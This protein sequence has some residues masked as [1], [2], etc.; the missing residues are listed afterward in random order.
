MPFRMS[1][2]FTINPQTR[3]LVLQQ[4]LPNNRKFMNYWRKFPF[5]FAPD[6]TR[7]MTVPLLADGDD[8]PQRLL[9]IPIQAGQDPTLLTA[10]SKQLRLLIQPAPD[11]INR[12]G[13]TAQWSRFWKANIPHK[14][15]T[16]WWRA[17]QGKI[18]TGALRSRIWR[19]QQSPECPICQHPV[20]DQ[21]HFF[22]LCPI[23]REIW[24]AMLTKYTNKPAWTADELCS[25]LSLSS[26]LIRPP[27]RFN[28]TSH[29]LISSTMVGIWRVHYAFVFDDTAVSRAAGVNI[30]QHHLDTLIT[31]NN[32]R[33]QR[34]QLSTP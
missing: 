21:D 13:S 12:H 11:E 3:L 7:A 17:L 30:S 16:I 27:K 26:R 6:V 25:L 8:L 20:E 18:A 9:S 4:D 23:K 15:R 24:N 34:K 22:F 10:D 19:Q 1:D 32:H 2:V 28:Y 29:Q 31:Q 14:A 33:Q 5:T